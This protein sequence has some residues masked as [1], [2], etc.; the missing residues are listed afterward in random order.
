MIQKM[1]VING[2]LVVLGHQ[3]VGK[4]STILRYVEKIFSTETPSTVG[5]SFFTSR[6]DVEGIT[7]K[8]QVWDTAGQERFKSMTPLFYRNANGALLVFDI[9]QRDTFDHMKVWVTELKRNIDEPIFIYVVGNKIDLDNREVSYEEALQYSHSIDAKYFECSAK[10]D[11]GIEQIFLSLAR[12]IIMKST[13]NDAYKSLEKFESMDENV[14]L[15]SASD[16]NAT[17]VGHTEIVG[18]SINSIAHGDIVAK[19]CC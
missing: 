5:A 14:L 4:T 2:K 6:I 17:D 7:V 16:Q 11:K 3:G 10:E 13:N 18:A 12:D 8:L 9:T 1:Q 19:R 15:A